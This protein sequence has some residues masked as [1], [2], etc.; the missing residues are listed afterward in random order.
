MPDPALP[1]L[2]A[3]FAVAWLVLGGYLVYLWRSQRDVASRLS[4]LERRTA[5]EDRSAQD[6]R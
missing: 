3:G 5:G 6:D 2:F 4:E 1:F